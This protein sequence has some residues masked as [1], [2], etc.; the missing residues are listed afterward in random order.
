LQDVFAL[1]AIFFDKGRMKGKGKR[2]KGKGQRE[3]GKGMVAFRA[4]LKK[5]TAIILFCL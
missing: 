5:L 2:A 3:K 4:K 1:R